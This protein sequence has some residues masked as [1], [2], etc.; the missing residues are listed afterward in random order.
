MTRTPDTKELDTAKIRTVA[1][2]VSVV[3]YCLKEKAK[4]L[5]HCFD[6]LHD[7]I[8]LADPAKD[9]EFDRFLLAIAHVNNA[10]RT[11][12]E[13]EERARAMQR[14]GLLSPDALRSVQASVPASAAV[15][16][17]LVPVPA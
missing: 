2:E 15:R 3:V 13:L 11:L 6:N 9:R 17:S 8:Y 16:Q 5:H 14:F 12:G 10:L 7:E 1:H 4:D